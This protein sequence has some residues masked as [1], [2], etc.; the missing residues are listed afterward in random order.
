[1]K[2]YLILFSIFALALFLRFYNYENR[3]TFGP[4]QARSLMVSS[5]YIKDKPSLLGQEY[6]RANSLGHKLY[7]SALFNYTLVPLLVVSKYDPYLIT[8][9]FTFLNILTA[10]VVYIL[11][12]KMFGKTISLITTFLFLFNSYMI[13]HSMFIWVL[14]YLPLIG[15]VSVYLVWKI[16]K[17]SL[18]LRGKHKSNIYDIL[19]LGVLSGIGFGL[20]YLYLIAILIIF[21]FLLKCSKERVKH[22]LLFIL[23]GAIGDFPQV[24]FD[25]RHNFYHLRSL[26]QYAIDTFAGSSDAGFTYY[27]FLMFWPVGLLLL[28]FVIYT[29]YNKNKYVGLMVLSIYFLLNI[30]S[31]LIN[32]NKPVGMENGL[33]Y[34]DLKYASKI[35]SDRSGDN[36]NVAT[37]YDF[38]TRG[39]TLRYFVQHVYGKNPKNDV[40]YK[41]VDEIYT[42][43]KSNYDFKNNNPWELN[44]FKPYNIENIENIGEG[45]SLFRLTKL[46]E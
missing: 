21:Y 33:K 24:F 23:G 36:F 10:V 12:K 44:V 4:E 32:F 1:M 34:K 6:F 40:Y 31:T 46:R 45:Y 16:Y 29:I 18:P 37:L 5:N 19:F 39:Y 13:Y 15:M 30:N 27:H 25:L 41:D 20:E 43:S 38:D 9:Y 2:N 22:A 8:I 35:I 11:S 28:S 3:I 14:N 7:T 42:L 17:Q 26:F